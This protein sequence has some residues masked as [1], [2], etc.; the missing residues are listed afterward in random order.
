MTPAAQY[1]FTGSIRLLTTL[2]LLG[3]N[4][5]IWAQSGI[6]A[7]NTAL[8][9]TTNT[10]DTMVPARKP[11]NWQQYLGASLKMPKEFWDEKVSVK[12]Y[13]AFSVTPDGS[14]DS[15]KIFSSQGHINKKRATA[16][17]LKPFAAEATR[18]VS[19]SP[20]W[21]PATRN[22]LPIHSYFTLPFSFN[23]N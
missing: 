21:T 8:P 9:D 15:V 22:G 19:G 17:Q 18:V 14:I 23:T 10:I 6:E 4:S 3:I 11:E 2:C 1:Q 13:V 20:K 7:T 5:A 12:I 16:D